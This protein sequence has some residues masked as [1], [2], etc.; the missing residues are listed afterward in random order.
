MCLAHMCVPVSTLME[1]WTEEQEE[2]KIVEVVVEKTKKQKANTHPIDCIC[3]S[4]P[5][6]PLD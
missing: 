2:G 5:W 6:V 4:I 3:V 1:L